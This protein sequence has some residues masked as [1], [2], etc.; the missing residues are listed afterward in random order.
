MSKHKSAQSTQLQVGS[1]G[2][3]AGNVQ[4]VVNQVAE[5]DDN[6]FSPQELADY[7]AID[8]SVLPFMLTYAKDEQKYRH[9]IFEKQVDNEHEVV[10]REDS[11]NLQALWLGWTVIILAMILS[12]VVIFVKLDT[13]AGTIMAGSTIVSAAAMFVNR[14]KGRGR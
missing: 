12:V 14:S 3:G 6:P 13:T 4:H 11:I 10:G 1:D 2:K 7:A 8:P 9:Y 5:H